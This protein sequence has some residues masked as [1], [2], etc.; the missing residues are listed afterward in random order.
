MAKKT[1][2]VVAGSKSSMRSADFL[3]GLC[4]VVVKT[5]ANLTT[6]R[7]G[8]I[9][10]MMSIAQTVC[11]QIVFLDSF[12]SIF[13][14][15]FLV[16]WAGCNKLWFFTFDTLCVLACQLLHIVRAALINFLIVRIVLLG[17]SWRC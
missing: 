14:R 5:T 3:A 4:S 6:F 1:N 8:T 15:Q 7:G 17:L 11:A 2:F 13:R 9:I 10:S 12:K 16:I